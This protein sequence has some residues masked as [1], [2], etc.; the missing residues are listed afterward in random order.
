MTAL[1]GLGRTALFTGDLPAAWPFLIQALAIAWRAR[2]WLRESDEGT[3]TVETLRDWR[4]TVVDTFTANLYTDEDEP[5]FWGTTLLGATGAIWLERRPFWT[6]VDV[7]LPSCEVFKIRIV[8]SNSME[9][10]SVQLDQTQI[11]SGGAR[12]AN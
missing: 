2:F 3:F 5:S 12:T 1:H 6:K 7:F 4:D 9:I 10:M 11:N 8:T